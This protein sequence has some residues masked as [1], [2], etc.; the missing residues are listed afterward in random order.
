MLDLWIEWHNTYGDTFVFF[1][2]TRPILWT[3]DPASL[4]D[5]TTDLKHFSKFDGLPNRSLYGQRLVG[6]ES[7][8]SGNGL[9]WAL[10]R[11][12]MT[13]FFAKTNM[14]ELYYACKPHMEGPELKRWKELIKDGKKVDLHDQLGITFTSYLQVMGFHNFMNSELIAK[15]VFKILEALPKQLSSWLSYLRKKLST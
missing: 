9:G 14:E 15:N 6:T 11:K 8:L 10:K 13:Q 4:K 12:V 7:I 1:L 5:I 2:S 3:A